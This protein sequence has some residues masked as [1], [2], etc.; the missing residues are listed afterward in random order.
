MTGEDLYYQ[1]LFHMENRSYQ[2]AIESFEK[3]ES[4]FFSHP[5]LYN[6]L[7]RA[8]SCLNQIQKSNQFF[9]KAIKIDA[10][11]GVAYYN[12]SVGLFDESRY[13]EA[14][15]YLNYAIEK[16]SIKIWDCYYLRSHSFF[17]LAIE[18]NQ[19]SMVG[20]LKVRQFYRKAVYDIEM[21]IS[22][23]PTENMDIFFI[24]GCVYKKIGDINKTK[25]YWN[26]AKKLGD[27]EAERLL[28]NL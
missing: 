20:M 11:F 5:A 19:D 6:D 9:L 22:L 13:S 27:K 3:A 28:L 23:S 26:K 1:G 14:I 17:K 24:A 25:F 16:E 8:Y 10:D 15:D 12:I 7:G 18:T 2:L 21:A 4:L